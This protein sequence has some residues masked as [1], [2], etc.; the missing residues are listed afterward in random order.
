MA[1]ARLVLGIDLG[2]TK[3]ASVV[4]DERGRVLSRVQVETPQDGPASVVDAMAQS[5]RAALRE[6]RFAALDILGIG[7]GAPGVVDTSE[8]SLTVAPNLA[9]WRS[10]PIRDPLSKAIGA[11]A[12]IGNDATVAA[13]GEHRFGAGKGTRHMV[14][15]TV[16]T[17]IGGGIVINGRVY[18]GASGSAGEIGHIPLQKDGPPCNCGSA[19]CLEVL[20]SGTALARVAREALARGERSSLQSVALD[21]LDAVAV[22]AA[23]AQGDRLAQRV[24]REGAEYLGM[25]LTAVVNIF[26]PEMIVIGGG[27]SNRWAEYIAPAVRRMEKMAFA[28][29][30]SDARVVPAALGTDVGTLGAAVLA[31][32]A[33]G[34]A[35]H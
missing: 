2:G 31:L 28:R 4:A 22:F 17:G 9:G 34:G 26:N 30:V 23:A 10:T 6:G 19:G 12:V 7:I 20:A 27:V 18:D 32:D 35:P 3:I 14:Y 24:V 11:P 15:I 16:S 1:T 29:P 33:F 5:A 13:L 8:G 21:D 25:G